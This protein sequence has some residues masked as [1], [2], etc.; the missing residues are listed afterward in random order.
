LGS[1]AEGIRQYLICKKCGTIE[2][3]E[4]D[5]VIK[6]ETFIETKVGEGVAEKDSKLGQEFNCDKCG[7][8]KCEITDL[9]MMFGDED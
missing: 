8:D 6:S 2:E 1:G 4:H 3:G 9:G 5:L 7:N